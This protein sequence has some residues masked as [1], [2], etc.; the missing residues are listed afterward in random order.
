MVANRVALE[1][2]SALAAKRA[3]GLAVRWRPD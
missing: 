1:A 2:I 3:S